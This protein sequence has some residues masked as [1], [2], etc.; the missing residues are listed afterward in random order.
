M[1]KF[2]VDQNQI[3]DS[4]INILGQDIR[5]IRN[6]LR[7]RED[8][9]II[10]ACDGINYSCK[11]ESFQEDKIQVKIL[12]KA[13][14]KNESNIDIILY[15][16][17]AKGNKMDYIIQKGTEIGIREFRI[18]DTRRTIVKIKNKRKEKSRIGRYQAI[19]EEAAKQSKRDYIPK[20]KGILTFQDMIESIKNEENILVPYESEDGRNIGQAL[21]GIKSQNIDRKEVHLIIG[22][23][24]G[25]ADKEIKDLK[26]IQA[27]I[28][29]LGRRI[30]RTE[31]AGMV[32]ATIILYD[33]GNI[34]V[35]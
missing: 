35:I 2:F 9:E 17:L 23:E 31:T 24:G 13:K 4:H 1:H 25:F 8:D 19:A 16:G 14:G 12:T 34:G 3:Y 32:A 28:F 7:L 30:L 11:I 20:V 27:D 29:T 15:Q 33:L 5:H 10:V 18:V 21:E 26:D 22:P 6:V